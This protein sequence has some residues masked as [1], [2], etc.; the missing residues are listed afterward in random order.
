MNS[1]RAE[2]FKI[3]VLYAVT[4]ASHKIT[5]NSFLKAVHIWIKKEFEGSF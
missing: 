4:A 1:S 5:K 3:G 2:S